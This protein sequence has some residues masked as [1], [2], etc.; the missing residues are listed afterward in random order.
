MDCPPEKAPVK[1][2]RVEIQSD[3]MPGSEPIWQGNSIDFFRN[4]P[5][6]RRAGENVL[7]SFITS[8]HHN[9]KG[10]ISSP[11]SAFSSSSRLSPYLAFGI[12]S[13]KEI[14]HAMRLSDSNEYITEPTLL[15]RSRA[16]LRSF[17]SRLK[18]HCHLFKN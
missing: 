7:N 8:R 16:S 1:L 17:M 15:K 4:L 5:G 11:N 9:Y 12:F 3:R 2:T 10:G 13:I 18:W 6:G 14:I